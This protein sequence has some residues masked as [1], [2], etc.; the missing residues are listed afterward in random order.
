MAKPWDASCARWIWQDITFIVQY[1]LFDR[2]F[3][4]DRYTLFCTIY[5]PVLIHLGGLQNSVG[6]AQKQEPT[7]HSQW[8]LHTP[9]NQHVVPC[10]AIAQGFAV[11]KNKSQACGVIIIRTAPQKAFKIWCF[12][13]Q[14][15]TPHITAVNHS[16][17]VYSH[18]CICLWAF[19]QCL[20]LGCLD[21]F[22]DICKALHAFWNV[23][24][25]RHHKRQSYIRAGKGWSGTITV[26][27]TACTAADIGLLRM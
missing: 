7:L 4:F 18:F 19:H 22:D 2:C 10:E 17:T 13:E 25:R 9:H 6:W 15:A 21:L 11:C 20:K 27:D 14:D 5:M 1:Y 24:F 12:V 3:Q 23:F 16:A 26:W 8:M